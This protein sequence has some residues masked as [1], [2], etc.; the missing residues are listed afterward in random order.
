MSKLIYSAIT[1]LDLFIEDNQ[2]KFDWAVPHEEAH[3]FISDLERSIELNNN[4]AVYRSTML[5]DTDEAVRAWL[6]REQPGLGGRV[7]LDL[8]QTEIGAAAVETLLERL[9]HGVLP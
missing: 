5:L 7:P 4:R 9:Y 1:S 8:M 3:A 6:S 2:G